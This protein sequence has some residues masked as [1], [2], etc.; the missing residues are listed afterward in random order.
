MEHLTLNKTYLSKELLHFRTIA[1]HESEDCLDAV[2][3]SRFREL[4]DELL[5]DSVMAIRR[6]DS[7]NF[8]PCN[9]AR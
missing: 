5:S 1:R 2:V 6:I 9:S 7:D 4:A 3:F 8:D